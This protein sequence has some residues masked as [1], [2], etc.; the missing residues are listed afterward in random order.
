MA[1]K[2]LPETAQEAI[3]PKTPWEKAREEKLKKLE[4][5]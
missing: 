5:T 3:I 2:G 1:E 4:A